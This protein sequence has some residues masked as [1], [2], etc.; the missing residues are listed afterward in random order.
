[1]KKANPNLLKKLTEPIK[2]ANPIGIDRDSLG[3]DLGVSFQD[4]KGESVIRPDHSFSQSSARGEMNMIEDNYKPYTSPAPSPAWV[5]LKIGVLLMRR[6]SEADLAGIRDL[7][8]PKR[9]KPRPY[10]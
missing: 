8:R 1:I 10:K 6:P 3:T 4:T 9:K 7:N 5:E 2:K